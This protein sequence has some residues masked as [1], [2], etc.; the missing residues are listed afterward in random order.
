MIAPACRM[1]PAIK[2]RDI[3]KPMCLRL[4]LLEPRAASPPP[5]GQKM[6]H[7][8][9]R[10]QNGASGKRR[11]RNG[12]LNSGGGSGRR[13]HGCGEFFSLKSVFAA[14]HCRRVSANFADQT[15][16]NPT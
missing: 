2:R 7:S 8:S 3:Q 6:V 14:C 10:S 4:F 9:Q 1:P 13:G 15:L 11:G 5:A 12:D 16:T